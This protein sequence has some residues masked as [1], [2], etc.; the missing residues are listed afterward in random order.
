MQKIQTASSYF[1]F[2]QKQGHMP[3]QNTQ[4]SQQHQQMQRS[5][6]PDRQESSTAKYFSRFDVCSTSYHL[7]TSRFDLHLCDDSSPG[8]KIR[9]ADISLSHNDLRSVIA[10]LKYVINPNRPILLLFA[11]AVFFCTTDHPLLSSCSLIRYHLSI[12]CEVLSSDSKRPWLRTASLQT[13][14]AHCKQL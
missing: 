3:D 6:A 12:C 5:V 13:L 9:F 4:R 2:C 8:K 10:F 7:V 14:C 11:G 1:M